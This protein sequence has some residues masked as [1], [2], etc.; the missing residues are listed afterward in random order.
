MPMVGW[1]NQSADAANILWICHFLECVM[2]DAGRKYFVIPLLR[3]G[4]YRGNH[5]DFQVYRGGIPMP[6]L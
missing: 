1:A 2:R 3:E 4:K 5:V 6:H